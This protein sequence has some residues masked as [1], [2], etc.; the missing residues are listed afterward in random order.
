MWVL[1]GREA[2]PT[3][4]S[5]A[6]QQP[7]TRLSQVVP[8]P[9]VEGQQATQLLQRRHLGSYASKMLIDGDLYIS[10]K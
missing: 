5:V 4:G 10:I 9:R 8:V 6:L 3:C 1:T 2:H 7:Q